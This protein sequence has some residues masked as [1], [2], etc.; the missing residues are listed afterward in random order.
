M[1]LATQQQPTLLRGCKRLL[2]P[3][4][5]MGVIVREEIVENLS[6]LLPK[7]PGLKVAEL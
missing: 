3:L 2:A 5:T 4:L 7:I 6:P 1:L